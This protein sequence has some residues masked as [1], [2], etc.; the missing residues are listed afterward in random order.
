MRL[1]KTGRLG[2]QASMTSSQSIVCIGAAHWDI[3]GHGPNL[4][5]LGQDVPGVIRRAP[6]GVALNIAVA[7][8]RQ[9]HAPELISVIGKDQAGDAL[10]EWLGASG[11][12]TDG[13]K[14]SERHATDAYLAIEGPQGLIGAIAAS[15]AL[16]SLSERDLPACVTSAWA[17]VIVDSGLSDEL[18]L[19]L[20]QSLSMRDIDLRLSA[21]APAKAGRLA[22]F[23]GRPGCT[24]YLNLEEAT[25]LSA[26]S[27]RDASSAAEALLSRGAERVL[28]TDGSKSVVDADASEFLVQYPPVI[29]AQRV[30]GAGDIF[31]ATHISSELRGLSR[32]D[33]LS[34]AVTAAS[35]HVASCPAPC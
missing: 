16:E 14:R 33:A 10:C 35:M 19:S 12:T 8:A 1:A 4:T 20:N 11:V 25:Q 18:L 32:Y 27:V 26:T 2:H 34:A 31:A 15:D 3:I 28:I 22:P 21:A 23:L 30:T 9:A 7:L 17:L 5:G 29:S 24:F 13:L 6:G